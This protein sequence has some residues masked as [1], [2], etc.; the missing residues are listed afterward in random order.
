MIKKR[1]Q[2]PD[3]DNT[4]QGPAEELLLKKT[5]LPSGTFHPVLNVYYSRMTFVNRN[6][7]ERLTI[8]TGL[9][10]SGFL[11]TISFPLLVIA[12]TKQAKSA[13]SP[14][15]TLMHQHHIRELSISKYCLGI[16]KLADGIKKN[17]FKFKLTQINKTDHG[18][19]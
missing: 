16:A 13:T 3:I 6:S 2:V 15:L 5:Q 11:K 8:D 7:N 1:I 12:E 17:N 10:Y 14:F 4:I 18:N 9:N 19:N